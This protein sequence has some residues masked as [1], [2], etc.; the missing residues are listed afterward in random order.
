MTSSPRI[1]CAL[2]DYI[3]IACMY[4]YLVKLELIDG[5]TVEGK[6]IDVVTTPEKREFLLIDSDRQR[7]ELT[8]LRKMTALTANAAFKDVTF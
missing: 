6:A 5:Q 7:I 8:R 1:S 2:H 3:E 4:G